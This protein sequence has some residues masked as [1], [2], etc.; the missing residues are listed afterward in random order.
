MVYKEVLLYHSVSTRGVIAGQF[1]EPYFTVRPAKF[2]GFLS[3][4]PDQPQRYNKYLT[5]LA[6]SVRAVSDGPRFFPV[7]LWP[8]RGQWEN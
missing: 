2:E 1:C 6:F 7:D 8:M 3:R 5:N 4:T